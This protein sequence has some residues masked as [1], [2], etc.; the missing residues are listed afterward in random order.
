MHSIIDQSRQNLQL[1]EI[2]ERKQTQREINCFLNTLTKLNTISMSVD[3]L[4]KSRMPL[5]NPY[6][7]N[8]HKGLFV[9]E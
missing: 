1:L 5:I 6:M 2:V 4:M 3:R 7:I 9:Y 8:A